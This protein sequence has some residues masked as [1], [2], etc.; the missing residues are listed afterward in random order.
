M[1]SPRIQ[2][3]SADVIIVGAGLAGL[4]AAALL[5]RRG[6]A[7]TVLEKSTHPGGRAITTPQDEFLFNL[8]P[9]AWYVAGRA[10]RIVT[11]L[12]VTLHGRTPTPTGAYALYRGRL[13]TLPIGLVSML[14]TGLLSLRGKLDV[15]RTLATIAR[16]DTSVLAS[17]P[18]S[19]WLHNAT[20]DPVAQ[21]VLAALIRT[22]T[23][24]DSPGVLSAGAALEQ[25]S[26]AMRGN[27]WYLDGGWQRVV[28][29]LADVASSCG[30]R[31]VPGIHVNEIV[32]D[33]GH[34]RGVRFADGQ[35]VLARHVILATP[36]DAA[37]SLGALTASANMVA[38]RAACL[39]LG[40]ARL[41]RSSATFAIG[42]DQP[43]YYS[44]HSATAS[45]AP[46]GRAVVH[47]AKYLDPLSR[48]N[49]KRDRA[50]LEAVMDL[51]QPG[52]RNELMT[53]RFLPSLAVTY[54]VPLASAGGLAGRPAAAVHGIAGLYLAGDWVGTDGQLANAAISSAA[55]AA[56]LVDRE[57][58]AQAA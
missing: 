49:P 38:A 3:D 7:V 43:V 23:Y 18:L 27:V 26:L 31:I 12:G 52:W 2:A 41:P 16:A 20:D 4:T 5:A 40:L 25:L 47:V 58:T 13:H 55:D 36:P 34:V 30:A 32:T 51:M 1:S 11:E 46:P 29:D 42:V 14:A 44:V 9:H 22:A 28:D 54:C 45:L 17:I 10:T 48:T 57:L 50:E 8:G 56:T 39:D 19:E 37:R 33:G 6:R 24:V 53:S 15:A 35:Y 21:M